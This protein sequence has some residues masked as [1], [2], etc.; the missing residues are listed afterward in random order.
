MI[1]IGFVPLIMKL[2]VGAMTQAAMTTG[3]L[4]PL[5]KAGKTTSVPT[6]MALL[7]QLAASVLGFRY[8]KAM[9]ASDVTWMEPALTSFFAKRKSS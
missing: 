5:T 8:S 9:R 3:D 4:N 6:S 7:N 1:F 2:S